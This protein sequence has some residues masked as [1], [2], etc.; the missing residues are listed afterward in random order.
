MGRKDGEAGTGWFMLLGGTQGPEGN[1][2][3]TKLSKPALQLRLSGIMGE[4]RHV[5]HLAPFGKESSYISTSIHRPGENI[6]M[7]LARLGLSKQ[8]LQDAGEGDSLLHGT[9]WRC[10]CQGLQM[11]R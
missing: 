11:E 7:F 9:S 10:G 8:A 1:R 3:T 5:E 2:T 4:T 6:G